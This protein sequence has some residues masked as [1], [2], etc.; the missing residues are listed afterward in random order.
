M[1]IVHI[2]PEGDG[3]IEKATPDHP[4]FD[5][6]AFDYTKLKPLVRL[7]SFLSLLEFIPFR[8]GSYAAP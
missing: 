5:R 6:M 4:H 8:L 2:N 3:Q 1:F 7:L